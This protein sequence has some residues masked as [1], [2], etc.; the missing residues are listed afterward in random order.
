[1]AYKHS[2]VLFMYFVSR[3]ISDAI[4]DVLVTG[5]AKRCV[6]WSG[7][8]MTSMEMIHSEATKA[9]MAIREATRCD[10]VAPDKRPGFMG[11]T[12]LD[13][14]PSQHNK[15]TEYRLGLLFGITDVIRDYYTASVVP[16]RQIEQDMMVAWRL[17]HY[18]VASTI[19]SVMTNKTWSMPVI[20]QKLYDDI[21]IGDSPEIYDLCHHI[22]GDNNQEWRYEYILYQSI[23]QRRP[24]LVNHLLQHVDSLPMATTQWTMFYHD[25]IDDMLIPVAKKYASED[26]IASLM[27]RIIDTQGYSLAAR[28]FAVNARGAKWMRKYVEKANARRE[29]LDAIW[30]VYPGALIDSGRCVCD[31]VKTRMVVDAPF[32][33]MSF[34]WF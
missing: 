4:M 1:M 28:I 22:V 25:I 12:T 3:G 29:I 9:D 32:A 23:T 13:I 16:F 31:D 11:V 17:G 27:K 6:K 7:R 10:D 18:N 15:T 34:V 24:R 33:D 8:P 2:P 21:I 30:H 14:Y 5:I 26:L 20:L 19:I